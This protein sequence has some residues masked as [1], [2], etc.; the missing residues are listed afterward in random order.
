M[1]LDL[2]STLT[3]ASVEAEQAVKD[4]FLGVIVDS[5]H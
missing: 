5:R 1:E 2:S 3:W 4:P